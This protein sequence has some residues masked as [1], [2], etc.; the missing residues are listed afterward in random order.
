MVNLKNK[1]IREFNQKD[2]QDKLEQ[3]RTE[4]SKLR[5]ESKKGTLRKESGK[6]R[7]YR[8]NIARIMTRLN[9]LTKK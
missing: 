5:V 3:M 4:L 9:E 1:T 2:L 6:L 7:K 8:K